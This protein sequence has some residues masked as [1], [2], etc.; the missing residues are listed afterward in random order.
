MTNASF[1]VRIMNDKILENNEQFQLNIIGTQPPSDR[2]TI[3]NPDN[4]RINIVDNDG[5]TC[6]VLY[7]IFA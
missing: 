4:T 5:E 1:N 6:S 7:N 2:I 3:G